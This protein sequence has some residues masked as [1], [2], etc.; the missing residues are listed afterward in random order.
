MILGIN[1]MRFIKSVA[2]TGLGLEGGNLK[3]CSQD[4]K[5]D[6]AVWAAE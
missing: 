3:K 6:E 5:K 1:M 4:S 2:E